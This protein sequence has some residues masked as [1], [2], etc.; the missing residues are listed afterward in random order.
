MEPRGMESTRENLRETWKRGFLLLLPFIGA[1][2]VMAGLVLL[3]WF[4]A[5]PDTSPVGSSD[6]LDLSSM[7]AFLFIAVPYAA[8]AL[9]SFIMQVFYRPIHS[10]AVFRK[11]LDVRVDELSDPEAVKFANALDAA[12]IAAGTTAP[13]LVFLVDDR[14]ANAMAFT[15]RDGEPT[16]GVTTGMLKAGL[17]VDEATAVMAH[18]LAHHQLRLNVNPPHLLQPEY[19]PN[20]LLVLYIFIPV[21]LFFIDMN[22]WAKA[23]LAVIY[24]MIL[25]GLVGLRFSSAYNMRL[26]DLLYFHGDI[27]AD[28]VAVKLIRDPDSLRRAIERV[29]E[30]NTGQGYDFTQVFLAKYLF[31]PPSTTIGDYYRYAGSI[32]AYR[33]GSDTFYAEKM[34]MTDL[35]GSEK[36]FFKERMTNLHFIMQGDVRSISDWDRGD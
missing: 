29:H 34:S 10:L 7:L 25:V 32:L 24:V 1:V 36:R 15:D 18:E 8:V 31:L 30:L 3:G 21:S 35:V 26:A 22:G 16:V 27:L 11:Y 17:P 13:R 23:M 14:R 9:G 19:I 33:L 5:R 20:L 6:E 2:A 28:S 4:L 12:S